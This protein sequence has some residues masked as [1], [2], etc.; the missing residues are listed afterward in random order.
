MVIC[1]E[2]SEWREL[3]YGAEIGNPSNEDPMEMFFRK[4]CKYLTVDENKRLRMGCCIRPNNARVFNG[5]YAVF[6][7]VEAT[8]KK[9][10]VKMGF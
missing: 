7:V 4:I 10:S 9:A 8:K 3:E 2:N 1:A 5:S 6:G